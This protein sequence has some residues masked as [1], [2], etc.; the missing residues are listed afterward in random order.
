MSEEPTVS[1]VIPTYD[2]PELLKRAIE[3]VR[4]QTYSELELVVVDGPSPQPASDI[5]EE[6]EGEID[7]IQYVR[8]ERRDGVTAARNTGLELATG[9]YIAF[10][11]DDDQWHEDKIAAQVNRFDRSGD[12]VGLIYTGVRQMGRDGSLNA[13][14]RHDHGGNVFERLLGENFIGTMSAVM[15][16]RE[17]IDTVGDFDEVLP[18]WEDWDFYLRV[19]REYD[20]CPV[21]KAHVDRHSG[22]HE[23]TSDDYELR[24]ETAPE[25]VENHRAAA[26]ERGRFKERRFIAGVELELARSAISN[27]FTRRARTHAFESLR[28]YPTFG[29]LSYLCLAAG[30]NYA[31][32]PVQK[33]KRMFVRV[34]KDRT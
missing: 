8:K 13:V 20:I 28:S 14:K 5:V 34:M 32:G 16:R 7:R 2:R 31:F 10:L 9:E 24:R 6:F 15:T 29:G 23:Q 19:A 3:S 26:A 30:G 25:L 22:E 4:A 18:V 17:V 11:D 12:D 33:L 1:V 21:L 27:G